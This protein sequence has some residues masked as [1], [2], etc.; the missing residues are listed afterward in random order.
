MTRI[1]GKR[2]ASAELSHSGDISSVTVL[3]TGTVVWFGIAF[4]SGGRLLGIE[5]GRGCRRTRPA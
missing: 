2:G 3:G 1:P 4:L 5:A